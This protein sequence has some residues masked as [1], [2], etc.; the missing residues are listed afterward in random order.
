MAFYTRTRAEARGGVLLS[1]SSWIVGYTEVIHFDGLSHLGLWFEGALRTPWRMRDKMVDAGRRPPPAPLSERFSS[2]SSRWSQRSRTPSPGRVASR[3]LNSG[4]EPE[5]RQILR[6]AILGIGGH[7]GAVRVGYRIMAHLE[8]TKK[9]AALLV[10]DPY[11]EF[12]S[13]G[14]PSIDNRTAR[15]GTL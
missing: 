1:R 13:A 11:N 9:I 3:R 12:S 10:I 15:I 8:F 6:A 14:P 4:L 5:T 7:T 2:C